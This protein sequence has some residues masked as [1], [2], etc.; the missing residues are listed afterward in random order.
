MTALKVLI[1]AMAL[2]GAAFT[3][4]ATPAAP[5]VDELV[6]KHIAAQGGAE[7]VKAVKSVKIT[8]TGQVQGLEL[9]MT[10]YMKRP[11]MMRSET[12]VQGR[13]IVQ[14]FDGTDSWSVNPL[15]GA[16]EPTKA[17]EAET[18]E[19]RDRGEAMLDGYLMDYKARGMSVEMV[20]KEDVEGS[21]AYKL[22]ITTKGGGTVYEYLDAA[23]YLEVRST[24]KI[25]QMG[26][27]MEVDS[28]PSNY[29][30][31]GGVMVPH[32]IEQR[33]AGNQI[34]KMAI[35]KYEANVPIDDAVFRFPSKPEAK[36]Q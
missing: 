31:E 1:S 5:T 33:I 34:M 17:G 24:L 2:A 30:P 36:K 13:M 21:P 35:D 7:K 29:K 27:T 25:T 4:T 26:Q 18:L 12:S 20:G 11:N 9:P 28:Y 23:T 22:K 14:A 8:A 32:S 10:I 19:A 16:E 15:T 3:Q 6:A